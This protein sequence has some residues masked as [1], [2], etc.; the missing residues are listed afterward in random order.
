LTC[1]FV[2]VTAEKASGYM[3]VRSIHLL[4]LQL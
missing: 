4:Y 2:L 1:P 3:P